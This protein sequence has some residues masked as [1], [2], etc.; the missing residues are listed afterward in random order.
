MIPMG[1]EIVIKGE[2]KSANLAE[3]YE[4]IAKILKEMN[5][6]IDIRSVNVVN[7]SDMV[8]KR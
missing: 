5:D 7:E 2:I 6:V 4:A 3:L 8:H 1:K